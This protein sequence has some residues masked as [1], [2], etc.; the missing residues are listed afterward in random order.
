MV[1]AIGM[2]KPPFLPSSFSDR[3]P[4]IRSEST[5]LAGWNSHL[6]K[7]T[8]ASMRPAFQLPTAG[9]QTKSLCKPLKKDL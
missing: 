4:R 1:A 2:H 9:M 5:R 8:S 7:H 6:P 3:A